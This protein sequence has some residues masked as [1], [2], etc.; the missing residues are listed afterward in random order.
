MLEWIALGY[1]VVAGG[2]LVLP[3]LVKQ[4]PYIAFRDKRLREGATNEQVAV[5]TALRLAMARLRRQA[6]DAVLLRPDA[7]KEIIADGIAHHAFLLERIHGKPACDLFVAVCNGLEDREI[8]YPDALAAVKAANP[9][10]DMETLMAGHDP[11][12]QEDYQAAF[13]DV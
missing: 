11:R 4:D 3:H 2:A 8:L 12:W 1:A 6:S 5:E 13:R 7:H 10:P 9:L